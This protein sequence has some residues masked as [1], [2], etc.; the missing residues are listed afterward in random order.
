MTTEYYDKLADILF[1]S[2]WQLLPLE[3]Q[4]YFVLMIGNAQIPMTYHGLGVA[5]L[6]LETF[7]KV[8]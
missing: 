8:Y 4:K 5:D 1:Q 7:R 6:N 3:L 2:K